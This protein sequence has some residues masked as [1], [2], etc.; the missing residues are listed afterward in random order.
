VTAANDFMDAV[1]ELVNDCLD[2]A[3]ETGG[4]SRAVSAYADELLPLEWV[5]SAA[6]LEQAL[7][8]A[9]H[10]WIDVVAR[11]QRE[12]NDHDHR[13]ST[14]DVQ[15]CT[16]LHAA[17][18]QWRMVQISLIK[19]TGLNGNKYGHAEVY[20]EPLV[21]TPH[22]NLSAYSTPGV[23]ALS[24]QG[25]LTMQDTAEPNTEAVKPSGSKFERGLPAAHLPDL[26]L[27]E[28][29]GKSLSGDCSCSSNYL[30][31]PLTAGRR[32]CFGGFVAYKL[33]FLVER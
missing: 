9:V 20:E 25:V 18:D 6:V 23:V 30:F 3:V 32:A 24:G 16:E 19:S 26:V 33:L 14:S 4:F 10:R 28:W 15:H 8:P 31:S 12:P 17:V 2:G 21:V 13:L 11:W 7:V 5:H 29:A 27:F 1:A 22:T